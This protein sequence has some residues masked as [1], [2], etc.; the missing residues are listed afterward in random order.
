MLSCCSHCCSSVCYRFSAWAERQ[1]LLKASEE[2]ANVQAVVRMS[3]AGH[4]EVFLEAKRNIHRG[5][6]ISFAYGKSYWETMPGIKA[7]PPDIIASSDKDAPDFNRVDV[8]DVGRAL[9]E[10]GGKRKTL[11]LTFNAYGKKETVLRWTF[12][13]DDGAKKLPRKARLWVRYPEPDID[14]N[15]WFDITKYSL[16]ELGVECQCQWTDADGNTI[17][18]HQQPITINIKPRDETHPPLLLLPS[19]YMSKKM[20]AECTRPEGPPDQY[21]W[22]MMLWCVTSSERSQSP[23]NKPKQN[24]LKRKAEQNNLELA[25]QGDP[26]E[27][28]SLASSERSQSP[29]KTSRKRRVQVERPCGPAAID[30]QASAA[31]SL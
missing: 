14:G 21:P 23:D 19:Q 4:K 5:D 20:I 26:A 15:R 2:G 17:T 27:T 25:S 29:D 3:K 8:F 22:T 24:S 18:N 1:A 30:H 7:S 16:P 6:W 13:G 9:K 12:G 28:G 11:K 10:M 31:K